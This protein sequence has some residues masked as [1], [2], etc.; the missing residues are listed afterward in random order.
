MIVEDEDNVLC[1]TQLFE[2]ITYE[3]NRNIH[4]LLRGTS[5][6]Y[7]IVSQC[8]QFHE[9][10]YITKMFYSFE[11]VFDIVMNDETLSD[12]FKT[13]LVFMLPELNKIRGRYGF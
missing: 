1:N 12:E 3:D 11:R 6:Q 9:T 13:T 7:S 2:K 5:F 10:P 4:F 8:W